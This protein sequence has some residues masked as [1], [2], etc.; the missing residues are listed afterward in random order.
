MKKYNI[1]KKIRNVDEDKILNVIIVAFTAWVSFIPLLAVFAF[2]KMET[3]V[4]VL[5]SIWLCIGFPLMMIL[6]LVWAF[7]E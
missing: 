5:T 6:L 2:L 7:I 3:F 1:I 4:F